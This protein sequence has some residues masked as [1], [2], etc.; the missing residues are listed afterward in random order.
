MIN[1]A[2]ILLAGAALQNAP[3]I[4]ARP[5]VVETDV[6]VGSIEIPD[7][8]IP[9]IVP[10]VMCTSFS[11]GIRIISENVEIPPTVEKGADCSEQRKKSAQLADKMLQ[12]QGNANKADRMRFIETALASIDAGYNSPEIT[13]LIGDENANIPA[14]FLGVWAFSIRGCGPESSG[15]QRTIA[16]GGITTWASDSTALQ[17]E[18]NKDW[19]I[20]IVAKMSNERQSWLI[21]ERWVLSQ[22]GA[23][24]FTEDLVKPRI[25]HFYFR[26]DQAIKKGT[27]E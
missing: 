17:I 1:S 3:V 15:L 23:M 13:N 8:I 21:R 10:Y 2:V 4:V 22:N 26:C 7:E 24:L 9:A 12:Q 25:R 14:G 11:R 5:V 20:N 16:S 27:A 19:D 6:P 18:H